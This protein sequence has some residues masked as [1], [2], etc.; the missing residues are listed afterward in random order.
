MS[1]EVK[2]LLPRL[3]AAGIGAAFFVIWGIYWYRNAPKIDQ[4][5]KDDWISQF[6]GHIPKENRVRKFRRGL[7]FTFIAAAI[8]FLFFLCNLAQ[9]LDAL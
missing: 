8:L 6:A 2:E 9:I 3:I 7:V 1:E 5:M 4:W